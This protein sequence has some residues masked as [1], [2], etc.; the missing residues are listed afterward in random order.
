MSNIRITE[1]EMTASFENLDQCH[2]DLSNDLKLKLEKIDV[3]RAISERSKSFKIEI[4]KLFEDNSSVVW[5]KHSVFTSPALID[6]PAGLQLDA[7]GTCSGACESFHQLNIVLCLNNREIIGTNFLK[8]E[9]S[10]KEEIRNHR[11]IPIYDSNILGVLITFNDS[12]LKAGNWDP[13]YANSNEYTFA[14]QHGYRGLIQS[15]I[16][17]MQLN[18]V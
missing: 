1:N 11:T 14:Y 2:L 7:R 3:Q 18:L 4:E 8:L 15:N 12:I 10:A 17:A 16:L 13:A 9:V 6:V 5:R